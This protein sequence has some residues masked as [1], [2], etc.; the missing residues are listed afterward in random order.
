MIKEELK[1]VD[2]NSRSSGEMIWSEHVR[3]AIF[4]KTRLDPKIPTMNWRQDLQDN[5]DHML[6]EGAVLEWEQTLIRDIALQAPRDARGFMTWFEELLNVGPGQGDPLFDYL[7]TTAT[8]EQMRWFI[9]QEVAGEAGFDD[10]AALTQLKLPTRAKLEVARNY[11]DEMGRGQEKGMHGPMLSKLA[12][13]LKI[14]SESIDEI[15][16]ESLALANILVGFAMN[17][18]FAYH[19]VGALGAIELT[20]PERARKVYEGLNRLGLS[21]EAQR[22]FRL[23]STLDIKH[24]AAWNTEVIEPLITENP[25]CTFSIAEG[26][27][28]RLNAGARCFKRYREELSNGKSLK[29]AEMH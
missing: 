14:H 27:L 8:I 18:R 2:K 28:I 25:E 9:Q 29:I 3:L 1:F 22:Y 20:A 12:E 17:R 15:V 26:A 6:L 13:E 7:E 16:P 11:W 21:P 4:N 5:L 23:H 24:S 10:L 19:S